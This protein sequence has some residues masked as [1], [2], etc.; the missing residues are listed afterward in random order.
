MSDPGYQGTIR[1]QYSPDGGQTV[2][3]V[4]GAEGAE[5]SFLLDEVNRSY[6]WRAYLE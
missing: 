6:W 5:Y 1:W 3:N 2:C 4:E